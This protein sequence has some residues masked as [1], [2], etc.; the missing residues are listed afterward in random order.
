MV[1]YILLVLGKPL[2]FDTLI[3]QWYFE[4]G[5]VVYKQEI[6]LI[7]LFLLLKIV[8]MVPVNKT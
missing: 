8:P 5:F 2:Y 4:E 1:V 3:C 6:Y 7:L